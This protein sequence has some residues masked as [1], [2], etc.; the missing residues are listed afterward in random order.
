MSACKHG[1]RVCLD[2]SCAALLPPLCCGCLQGR[3]LGSN[4]AQL[5]QGE[6][7]DL[8]LQQPAPSGSAGSGEG[9][10]AG[11]AGGGGSSPGA[12]AG[13]EGAAAAVVVAAAATE[14]AEGGSGGGADGPAAMDTQ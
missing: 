13:A 5:T 2:A 10:E 14:A 11:K 9:G 12:P 6:V 7:E 1:C 3:L 8:L 4:G